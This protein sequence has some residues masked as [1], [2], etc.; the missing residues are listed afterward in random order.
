M[1]GIVITDEIQKKARSLALDVF[2]QAVDSDD[3]SH[4]L[5]TALATELIAEAFA[6]LALVPHPPEGGKEAG[7]PVDNKENDEPATERQIELMRKFWEET[8]DQPAQRPLTVKLLKRDF[9][10]LI[11]KIELLEAELAATLSAAPASAAE[12]LARLA[13]ARQEHIDAVNHY[14]HRLHLMNEE[15]K[16]GNWSM[17]V[18]AENRAI[19]DAQS[20]FIKIAQDVADAALSPIPARDTARDYERGVR[21]GVSEAIQIAAEQAKMMAGLAL[22]G[23]EE[24][25]RVREGMEAALTRFSQK[26]SAT[27]DD[28]FV[29]FSGDEGGA[30]IADAVIDWMIKHKLADY[31]E[32]L[33]AADI[34]ETLDG[35]VRR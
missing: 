17:K 12:P 21:D 8:P 35:L 33:S 2:A 10:S 29:N 4:C 14:N 18:D 5:D 27:L 30:K 26:L 6:A 9:L 22:E 31:G 11:A 1:S 15:R 28:L 32:E 3:D 7:E 25:A 20:E 16:R 13:K 34:V 23:F 24:N 19:S